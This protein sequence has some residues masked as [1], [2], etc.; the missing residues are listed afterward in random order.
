MSREI[1]E[2]SIQLLLSSDR[3]VLTLQFFGGEALLQWELVKHGITYGME[4]AARRG[5]RLDFVLSSNGWSLESEKLDWLK[6]FPV[7]L[8][9]SLDG[10][11]ETQRQNRPARHRGEDSY[12]NSIAKNAKAILESGLRYDV[13]MVLHPSQVHRLAELYLH[14]VDLGF[15]R[16]QINYALGKNWTDAHRQMI[17]TQLFVLAEAL[18]ARPE[19]VLVNGEERPMPMRLNAEVTVDWDGTI[20]GGNA[21]LHETE[22]KDRFRLGHLSDQHAFDRY[23]MDAP[24]NEELVAWSYPPEVTAN[25]LKIGAVMTDFLRWWR[26]ERGLS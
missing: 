1:M 19:V 4:Q 13:I 6:S 7:K 17:A 9:L 22:H 24:R 26:S 20:Y 8:E 16:V 11:P 5:K 18:K 25:N 21:F 23:W 3:D 10:N 15:K 12:A 14:I 2:E